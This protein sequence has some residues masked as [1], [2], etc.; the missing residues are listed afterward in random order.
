MELFH[1]F[2]WRSFDTI[3]RLM[4]LCDCYTA[5]TSVE[6]FDCNTLREYME[7]CDE[8]SACTLETPTHVHAIT[9]F[10]SFSRSCE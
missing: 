7:L 6:F 5:G 8:D 2:W 1:K 3:K 9:L 4:E 10:Q